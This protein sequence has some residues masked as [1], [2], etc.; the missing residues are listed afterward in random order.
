MKKKY[1]FLAI[2]GW[3]FALLTVSLVSAQGGS[4]ATNNEADAAA[5]LAA[6]A[7]AAHNPLRPPWG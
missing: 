1:M 3:V 2:F 5:E 4:G 7:A 6:D